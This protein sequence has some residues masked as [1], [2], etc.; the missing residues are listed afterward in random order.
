MFVGKIL[1]WSTWKVTHEGRLQLHRITDKKLHNI[2]AKVS[3]V[4]VISCLWSSADQGGC[5]NALAYYVAEYI[6]TVTS[7]TTE[8]QRYNTFYIHNL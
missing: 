3:A 6:T 2:V 7:F 5:E 8:G 1:E 4:L